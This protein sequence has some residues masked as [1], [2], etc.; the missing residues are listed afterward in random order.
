MAR[1]AR[2]LVLR[3][4]V[5]VVQ[6]SSLVSAPM[7]HLK[8]STLENP[9]VLDRRGDLV[10][11]DHL[12]LARRSPPK[13]AAHKKIKKVKIFN[14]PS[15]IRQDIVRRRAP[16]AGPWRAPQAPQA[17]PSRGPTLHRAARREANRRLGLLRW[18]LSPEPPAPAPPAPAPPAPAP[19]APVVAPVVAL[20]VAP[21]TPAPAP[22]AVVAPN[23]AAIAA[24]LAATGR[25][26][27]REFPLT[28]EQIW[29]DEAQPP[30]VDLDT[31]FASFR[32]FIRIPH[33]FALMDAKGVLVLIDEV[34]ARESPPPDT[35][36]KTAS[37][38]HSVA[39]G[40]A[41][42]GRGKAP[43]QPFSPHRCPSMLGVS[44]AR[45]YQLA[46]RVGR[47]HNSWR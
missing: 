29:L 42:S 36:A 27:I 25:R 44:P 41:P 38:P 9:W 1:R 24:A 28:H 22:P 4:L 40:A 15:L 43:P 5:T 30:D 45:H 13:K 17:G 12:N 2:A 46:K 23:A 11:S 31:S 20:V 26:E 16:P 35:A 18:S 39:R 33:S 32:L 47:G 8:G 7:N 3:L 19:P 34:K 14:P 10:L 21:P 37:P 6:L